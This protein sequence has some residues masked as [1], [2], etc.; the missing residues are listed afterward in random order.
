M[1]SLR[2]A[3]T[4]R[5]R[6]VNGVRLV[7]AAAHLAIAGPAADEAS[8]SIRLANSAAIVVAARFVGS[9]NSCGT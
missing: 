2:D 7:I 1:N 6:P 4:C 9:G 8:H 3:A 5:L